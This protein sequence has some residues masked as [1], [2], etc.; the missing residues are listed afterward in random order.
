MYCK[1][2]KNVEQEI[3]EEEFKIIIKN[4]ILALGLILIGCILM[5]AAFTLGEWMTELLVVALTNIGAGAAVATA[6]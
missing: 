3:C 4:S 6:K 5:G 2:E 1:E